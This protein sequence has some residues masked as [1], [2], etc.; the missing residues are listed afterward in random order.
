MVRWGWYTRILPNIQRGEDVIQVS[1]PS[2]VVLPNLHKSAFLV[3]LPRSVYSV[4][5]VPGYQVLHSFYLK[6]SDHVFNPEMMLSTLR[7]GRQI[8]IKEVNRVILSMDNQPLY[9]G[10][11]T[12]SFVDRHVVSHERANSVLKAVLYWTWSCVRI[13]FITI[14]IKFLLLTDFL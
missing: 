13:G 11:W 12:L 8:G 1:Y 5:K 9:T 14:T 4:I 3:L 10:I 7:V 2:R 6:I